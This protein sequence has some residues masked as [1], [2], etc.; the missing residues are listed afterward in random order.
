MLSQKPAPKSTLHGSACPPHC[1]TS[2]ARSWIWPCWIL[3]HHISG[4]TNKRSTVS[5]AAMA[6][7]L[8]QCCL[9]WR[10]KTQSPAGHRAWPSRHILQPYPCFSFPQMVQTLVSCLPCTAL[11]KVNV[12]LSFSYCQNSY[13]SAKTQHL[14]PG[15]SKTGCHHGFTITLRLY[16]HTKT[17]TITLIVWLYLT[18]I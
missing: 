10:K 13:K 18:S 3:A 2:T 5:W 16:H 14:I 11:V 1:K 12:F 15:H 4:R 17:F 6:P 7:P 8:N 9:V